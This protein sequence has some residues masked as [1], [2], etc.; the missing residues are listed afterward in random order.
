M[1]SLSGLNA[2]PEDGDPLAQQRAVA[3][4]AGQLDHADP[5]AHVDVVDLAQ[6]RQRLV[7]AQLAGA[8][9]ER[10]DVL[11]QAAAAEAEPGVEELAADPVVVADRVG[12]QLDVG[13]GRLAQ[14]GHRVDEGDLG[15]EEGV[16][17]R[18]HHLG[19]GVVGDHLRGA[20]LDDRRVDLVEQRP[21][22]VA[23]RRRRA[24]RRPAGRGAGCPATAKPSRRNSG[25]QASSAP[26]TLP[27]TSSAS[28]AAVPDRHG[29]L[30]DDELAGREDAE[31]RLGRAL[32]V[33][34]V[35]GVLAALLRRA[36]AE[37]VHLRSRPRRRSR[38]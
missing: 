19:G 17:R 4:L 37:E 10:A 15:G 29:R 21:G 2:A 18:L 28:R 3:D 27:A 35:G 14:L 36:H 13:A 16:G 25:F 5:A 30:A 33:A 24:A 20:A 26:G 38:C 1:S 8:G 31:Q 6:E 23:V 11:G 32:D 34:Q 22:G 9:H 7:G 12:Q